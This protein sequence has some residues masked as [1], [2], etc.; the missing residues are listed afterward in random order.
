MNLYP[1]LYTYFS[2]NPME[3]TE[4]GGA[5]STFGGGERYI[6]GFGGEI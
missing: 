4:I 1:N 6:Q 5:C 3:K 2:G